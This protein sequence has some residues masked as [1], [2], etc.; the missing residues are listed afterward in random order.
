M[1]DATPWIHALGWTLVHF[2]WQG[3]VVGAA[4]A[5]VRWSLP[6]ARCHSR[7]AAGLGALALLA[8]CPVVTFAALYPRFVEGASTVSLDVPAIASAAAGFDLVAALE[9]CLPWLV[10]AWSV[11]VAVMAMR[12][13][14]QWRNLDRIVRRWSHGCA[15]IDAMARG[16]AKRFGLARIRVLV[17]ER[18]DSPMLF[19]WVRPVILLP[20]AVVLGFPREQIELILAHEF[21][22]L[23]RYDHLVNLAQ[24]F[25]ETV[26]FYHPVVHWI[27][28][29]VRN[30]REYCCDDLVLRSSSGRTHDYARTLA[31]LEELRHATRPFALAASGGEL[32]QRIRRVVG[33]PMPRLADERPTSAR[34]VLVALALGAGLLIARRNELA[35]IQVSIVPRLAIATSGYDPAPSLP[36]FGRIELPRLRLAVPSEPQPQPQPQPVEVAPVRIAVAEPPPPAVN[37]DAPAPNVAPVSVPVPPPVPAIAAAEVDAPV[38]RTSP[39]PARPVAIHTVAPAFP[40]SAGR[41]GGRVEASFAIAPDGSPRDIRFVGSRDAAFEREAEKALRQ[42]RFDP[43]SLP[44]GRVRYTQEFV[45][46]PQ[47]SGAH[48]D[49]VYVTGSRICRDI[50]DSMARSYEVAH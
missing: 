17:S 10:L 27:S 42:W 22:H 46:A 6:I 15:E 37:F 16:L 29:D 31:A 47:D 7:Y 24:T 33:V 1:I 26:L 23:R 2:L 28:N 19:G 8:A 4:F 40:A 50:R 30:E 43:A 12:A 44:G 32:L 49:C 25:L 9:R 39:A 18:V 48:D 20:A 11:G 3:L 13:L 35:M 41:R 36:S 34:W 14:A 5:V 21:G 45:F 38:S